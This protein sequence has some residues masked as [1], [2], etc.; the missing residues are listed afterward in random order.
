MDNYYEIRKYRQGS[1]LS[2]TI[3]YALFFLDFM[4]FKTLKGFIFPSLHG[5]VVS[6]FLIKIHGRVD[7][8]RVFRRL[9]GLK[10]KK[11]IGILDGKRGRHLAAAKKQA[12][13]KA[14]SLP[15]LKRS[16]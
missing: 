9:K 3:I 8:L 7:H 15:V 12:A 16:M 5:F 13:D 10:V 1:V 6:A 4:A 14:G 11:L 2:A